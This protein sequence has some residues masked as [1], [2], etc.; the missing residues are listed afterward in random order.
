VAYYRRALKT[1][2]H[3]PDWQESSDALKKKLADLQEKL[4]DEFPKE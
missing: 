3:D 2:E 4:G 1:W